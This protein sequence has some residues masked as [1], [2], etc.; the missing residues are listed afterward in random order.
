MKWRNGIHNVEPYSTF[1]SV[2]SD[3]RVVSARVKLSLRSSGKSLAKQTKLD[4]KKLSEGTSMQDQYSITVQN[5]LQALASDQQSCTQKYESFITANR[6]TAEE[7]IPGIQRQKRAHSNDP[8]VVEQRER[9]KK[10]YHTYQEHTDE[11]N[12]QE[13]EE[14]KGRLEGAY[15]LVAEEEL[16]SHIHEVEE[17]QNI[18]STVGV[19]SS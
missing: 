18:T 8:R 2:G 5:R 12:R 10:A 14:A 9:I 17:A 19:G 11:G 16:A 13:L 15:K 3:H 7:L 1:A 4:W 6:E